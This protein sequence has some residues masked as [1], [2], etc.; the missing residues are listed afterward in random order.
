M[1]VKQKSAEILVVGNEL[2][3]G[4]TLDTNSYWLSEQLNKAGL[5]IERKTI[6]RDK[7][8]VISA[9]FREGLRRK[10]NWL[11][12]IGGLGPTFDD[13]TIQGLCKS[14]HRK[15]KLDP[16]AIDMLKDSYRR[17][18]RSLK[19]LTRASLKMAMMPIG[20]L[21]LLNP[22]GSAPGVLVEERQ[23]TIISLPGVP[24]EMKQ[25][26]RTQVLNEVRLLSGYKSVERWIRI[27]G[28]P[29][30]KLASET[31]RLFR[32]HRKY[33]Y[34]KSHP[35]GFQS[36]KP[37]LN[38]QIILATPTSELGGKIRALDLISNAISDYARKLGATV[39]R[40]SSI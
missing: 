40:T 3:N 33:L 19:R 34:V 9:S 25:I 18:G 39:S 8:D 13:L 12:S 32:R 23:T 26:F 30:S 24:D 36:N 35:S 7:L 38:I 17:R 5:R 10:P 4:T 11:F 20:A 21:P 14:I 1:I 2:L 15:L 16:L 31:S 29:E 28:V 27:V 22:V 37:V 6:V